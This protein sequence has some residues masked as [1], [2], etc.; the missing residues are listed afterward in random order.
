MTGWLML[1]GG[2]P[3][4]VAAVW[5]APDSFHTHSFWPNFGVIYNG[6]ISFIFCYWAWFRIL[7][8]VPAAVASLSTLMIP[9]V[10]VFSG[11][12]VL[13]EV[14]QWNDILALL[15]VIAALA[16]VLV[17]APARRARETARKVLSDQGN[18][19]RL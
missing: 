1:L 14:P 18:S 17:A 6:F 10:G 12:L 4:V 19:A 3:I 9:V 8:M 16:T 7:D 11:M 5:L 2:L 15:L 13:G